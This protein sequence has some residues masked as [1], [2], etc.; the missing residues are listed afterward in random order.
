MGVSSLYVRYDTHVICMKYLTGRAVRI[1]CAYLRN[2]SLILRNVSLI[3]RNVSL[4]LS[5]LQTRRG[6]PR[7][8]T[9][10]V[11]AGQRNYLSFNTVYLPLKHSATY[12]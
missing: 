7:S 4:I 2:V 5:V 1:G 11:V 8:D 12:P 6:L 9:S 3:L 10:L